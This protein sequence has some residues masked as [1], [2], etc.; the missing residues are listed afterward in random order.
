MEKAQDFCRCKRALTSFGFC[1][2]CGKKEPLCSCEILSDA[3]QQMRA[4]CEALFASEHVRVRDQK[5]Y[6]GDRRVRAS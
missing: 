1:M 5:G 6:F 2:G 4:Q 3:D